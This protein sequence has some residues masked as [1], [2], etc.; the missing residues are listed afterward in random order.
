M[1]D[2]TLVAA[3]SGATVS[4]VVWARA[5]TSV[6]LAKI[7]ASVATTPAEFVMMERAAAI[8]SARRIKIRH[9]KTQSAP[10]PYGL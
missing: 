6:R 7:R 10:I 1:T 4:A 8:P 2:V 3:V 5:Y 9:K